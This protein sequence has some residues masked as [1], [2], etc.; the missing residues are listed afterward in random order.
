VR[1]LDISLHGLLVEVADTP[2]TALEVGHRRMVELSLGR[3]HAVLEA[4][5]RRRDGPRF[6]LLFVQRDVRP[7][8]LARIVSEIGRLWAD[9]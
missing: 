7:K 5:V 3:H 8:A 1:P 4:E 6:G 2:Q 9:D